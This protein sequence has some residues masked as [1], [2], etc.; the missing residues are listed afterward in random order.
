MTLILTV[1][2]GGADG[3][4]DS[5]YRV[6]GDMIVVGRSRNCDWCLP[7]PTNA[8]SSRHCELR[9]DGDAWLVKDIS[10]NGTFLNGSAERM[11]EEHRLAEGD[12][13]RIGQYEIVA[14][15]AADEEARTVFMPAAEPPAPPVESRPR[16]SPRRLPSPRLLHRPSPRRLPSPFLRRPNRHRPSRRRPR[17]PPLPRPRRRR[18]PPKPR[19]T[20]CPTMSR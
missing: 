7:D 11:A 1:E 6:E 8:I 4:P 20:R 2:A 13:L 5:P 9:R 3:E 19:P 10:T 14:G 15:F 12:R 16:Q 18:P 17:S